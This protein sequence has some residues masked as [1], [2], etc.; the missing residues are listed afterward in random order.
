MATITPIR[1]FELLPL[2]YRV[3]D[4]E[5]SNKGTL[6]SLLDIVD[7]QVGVVRHDIV[8][9]WDNL[10]IETCDD[11]VV[12]YIGDLVGTNLIS[13]SIIEARTDVA[14]TIH[15]RRRKGTVPMLEELARDVT[16]WSAKVVEFYQIL[17]WTQNLNHLRL[18][19]GGWFDVRDH[20]ACIKLNTAFDTTAHGVDVRM[21]QQAEGWYNIR[22][23]GFFLWRIK[24]YPLHDIDPFA[25]Q[26]G[27]HHF[28]FNSLGQPGPLFIQPHDQGMEQEKKCP[29]GEDD[30]R[31]AINPNRFQLDTVVVDRHDQPDKDG[32]VRLHCDTLERS[33]VE[34]WESGLWLELSDPTD[35]TKTMSAVLIDV[36]EEGSTLIVVPESPLSTQSRVRAIPLLQSYYN[37]LRG[38]SIYADDHVISP[39]APAPY[40][41]RIIIGDLSEWT[42]PAS[43]TLVIDVRLGR[44]RFAANEIPQG[45]ITTKY[46]YGFSG[47]IGAGPY[48]RDVTGE[49]TMIV[50]RSSGRTLDQA[51]I[52]WQMNPPEE[53]TIEVQDSRTHYFSVNMLRMPSR[54]FSLTI[55]AAN[56]ERPTILM[57]GNLHWDG[58][59]G[60][61]SMTLDGL[62]MSGGTIDLKG[63][64]GQLNIMHCTL[65]PGGGLMPDGVTRSPMKPSLVVS[66]QNLGLKVSISKSIIG[67]LV[68][69]E[70]IELLSIGDSIV[71]AHGGTAITGS[72][73]GTTYA[74]RTTI[75]STTIWGECWLHELTCGSQSIFVDAL[76]VERQQKGCVRFSYLGTGS[77]S[78]RRY[79]CVSA[80]DVV[81]GDVL[82]LH[83]VFSSVFFGEPGYGKLNRS[84]SPLIAKGAEDGSEMGAFHFLKIP[85]R[86]QNLLMR[87]EEYLPLG[88]Y[89]ALNDV[90]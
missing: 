10:F 15:Y 90:G 50:S 88:L 2:I 73:N 86:E 84:C 28:H 81:N 59:D 47:D 27:P 52:E 18:D 68:I 22:N 49:S 55:R 78:P 26:G 74:G 24:S 34:K 82:G 9:L 61:G 56:G 12:P 64:L 46:N 25:E 71:D 11:W 38:F 37:N 21:P 57:A 17:G 85:Q 5:P 6:E 36:Q 53:A 75:E 77:T 89:T 14:K 23:I 7:E 58:G 29:I 13:P 72:S 3:R 65:D 8:H 30:V 41:R 45:T 16:G 70:E 62:L 80:D 60:S 33:P 1:L 69:P 48:H 87:L 20:A 54:L 44:F 4:A 66:A 35:T 83:P 32:Y 19:R 67:A 31:A 63:K 39:V 76:K 43:E 40:K 79:L 51:L 42:E